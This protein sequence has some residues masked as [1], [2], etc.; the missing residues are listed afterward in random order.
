M[1]CPAVLLLLALTACG[2][3][4]AEDPP[5]G[6]RA[7][8]GKGSPLEAPVEAEPGPKRSDPPCTAFAPMAVCTRV[9]DVVWVLQADGGA[10]QLT[11]YDVDEQLARWVPR[12]QG[13]GGGL[14]PTVTEVDLTDAEQPE[15][16]VVYGAGFDVV[17]SQEAGVLQVVA[18]GLG[19]ASVESGVVVAGG[20]EV[21]QQGD[22]WVSLP[23]RR[24]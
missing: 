22:R 2:S 10:W 15:A 13:S 24:R 1:R 11:S 23:A 8:S 14:S 20:R 12:L 3:E 4:P 18:H 16:L 9:G 6:A 5:T 7:L 19:Q 17:S 21:R